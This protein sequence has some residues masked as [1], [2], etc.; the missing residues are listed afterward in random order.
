PIR[1]HGRGMAVDAGDDFDNGERAADH[2][3]GYRDT[4][5]DVHRS[6]QA[7]A[8]SVFSVAH[9][10]SAKAA[11]AFPVSNLPS[12]ASRESA[13]AAIDSALIS[14]CFRRCSRLSL[15]PKPSVPSVTMRPGSQGATWSATTFMESVAATTGPS[16]PSS[17]STMYG[18]RAG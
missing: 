1:H 5:A 13:A 9:P 6:R 18:V 15:R 4:L 17:A 8:G 14:K 16:A 10:N 7:R 2:H 3:P 11:Q 12:R